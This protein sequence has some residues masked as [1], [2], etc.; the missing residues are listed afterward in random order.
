MLHDNPEQL[1]QRLTADLE[2][3]SAIVKTSG[4]QIN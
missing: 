3:W 1:A 2:K 4:A